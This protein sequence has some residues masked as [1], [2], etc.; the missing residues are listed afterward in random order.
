M[1]GSDWIGVTGQFVEEFLLLLA[2][3]VSCTSP[4]SLTATHTYSLLLV[5]LFIAWYRSV[6]QIRVIDEIGGLVKIHL[7]PA[8]KV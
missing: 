6:V 8:L 4:H 2:S 3:L 5:L 7:A 1:D